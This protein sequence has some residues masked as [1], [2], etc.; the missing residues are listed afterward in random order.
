MLDSIIAEFKID[1]SFN[2]TALGNAGGFGGSTIWKITT[3][4]NSY[5]LKRWPLGFHDEKRIDWIH[6]VL[7]FA[8]ANGCPELVAPIIS[9][10]G[11]TYLQRQHAFWELNH[12]VDG[13]PASQASISDDQIQSA[14]EFLARFH[15]ATARYHFSFEP[16]NKLLLIRDRL[17]HLEKEV[18]AIDKLIGGQSYVTSSDWEAYKRHAPGLAKDITKFILVYCETRLP[19]QP[20]IRDIRGE[21]LYFDGSTLSAV[22]DF[23]AMRIDSLACDLSRLLGS[24]LGDD[25]AKIQRWLD[26][27]SSRRQL[28]PME[29]AIVLPM[30][31]AGVILG[32]ANWLKWIL[33]EKRTF[34]DPD[35]VLSR[36]NSL[37]QQFKNFLV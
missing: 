14:I 37:M 31:H 8:R 19:V 4:H 21:H 28:S 29:R 33:L 9:N 10:S 6:R 12:W 35:L 1:Q 23:G 11:R 7:L 36:V 18:S 20:V 25:A 30:I 3:N 34:D 17:I 15:Q 13:E 16:S 5:C 26:H 27:F 24:F 2:A 22:I 32:I